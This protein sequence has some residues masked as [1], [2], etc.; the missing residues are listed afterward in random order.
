MKILNTLVL[1]VLFLSQLYAQP[2]GMRGEQRK[3]LEEF[4]KIKLIETLDL[5]EEEAARFFPAYRDHR[6]RVQKLQKERDRL[7]DELERISKKEAKFKTEK[8]EEVVQKLNEVEQNLI[9]NRIEF[10]NQ[11]R[12]IL[13]AFK[14][15]RYYVFERNFMR[16]LN[17]LLMMR[18]HRDIE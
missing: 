13:P 10:H 11:L 9:R 6:D 1:V 18:R 2:F 3:R 16:E 4:K 5:N 12:N 8:F 17:K 7:L 14:V 15:A